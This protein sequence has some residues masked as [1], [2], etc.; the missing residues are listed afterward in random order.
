MIKVWNLRRSNELFVFLIVN[1]LVS[2][3]GIERICEFGYVIV[4]E[5]NLMYWKKNNLIINP[6]I[7]KKE[8]DYYALRKIIKKEKK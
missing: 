8:W 1:L 6:N 2:K 3:G 4:D 7:D 5:K